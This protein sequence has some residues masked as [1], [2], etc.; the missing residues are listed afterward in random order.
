MNFEHNSELNK[1]DVFL[2]DTD[3]CYLCAEKEKCALIGAI[4]EGVV[5]PSQSDLW[6]DKCP[7]FKFI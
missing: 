4:Q 6:I 1:V 2:E 7:Q 3:S 5:Y